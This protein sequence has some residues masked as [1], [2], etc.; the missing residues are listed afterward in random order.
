[1]AEIT[2]F[3][4]PAIT[5]KTKQSLQMPNLTNGTNEKT[6]INILAHKHLNVP[7]VHSQ[8]SS[9]FLINNKNSIDIPFIYNQPYIW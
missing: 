4:K 1:M 3:L 8:L 5:L 2:S 7:V 9:A 6:D